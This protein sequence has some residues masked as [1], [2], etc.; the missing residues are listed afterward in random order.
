M[1]VRLA[2]PAM[3]LALALSECTPASDMGDD[4]GVQQTSDAVAT[5]SAGAEADG[6][7]RDIKVENDLYSFQ[8][9][10]PAAVGAVPELAQLLDARAREGEQGLAKLAK[11][12]R[13][14]A[15]ENGFPYNAYSQNT[16]WKV[17]GRTP[18]WISLVADVSS[19][20]GG[21]HGIYGID[22]VLWDRDAKRTVQPLTLFTSPE[23][24]YD[25]VEERFCE[26]LDAERAKRRGPTEE[27]SEAADNPTI[28]E[29]DQCPPMSDLAIEV[30]AKGKVFDTIV[31]YAGPYVAGPYVEGA[32]E[33][34]VAVDAAVREAV[35]PEYR[36]AFGG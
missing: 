29:F 33:I 19:Y 36:K 25:A 8:Y 10:Y 26:K 4:L 30:K 23:A 13:Q 16:E 5:A 14:D 22:P 20:S 6:G 24:L 7:A 3:L 11:Q 35:K 28:D 15:R 18:E 31:M 2:A 9:S 21:A 17:I 32:Y 27:A 1:I 34:P 12:A